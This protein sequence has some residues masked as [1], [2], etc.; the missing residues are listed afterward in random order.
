[1]SSVP[2]PPCIAPLFVPGDRPERFDK[3]ARSGADAVIIDLEDAVSPDSKE[4]ARAALRTSF[5]ALPV[6]VRVNAAGTAWHADDLAA[7]DALPLAGIVLPKADAEVDLGHVATRHALVALIETGKGIAD[8]RRV[9][10]HPRV[11][12]LAFGSIDYTADLGCGHTRQALLLPRSELV[13]ASRLAGLP[14]PLDGVTETLDDPTAV[15]A[16]A[17][18]AAELG[19]GGKLCIHP[20]QI[21]AVFQGMLPSQA[22]ITWAERVLGSSSGTNVIDGM[23]VDPPVRLRAANI[24]ARAG[25]V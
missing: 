11:V 22:D 8:A 7:V 15:E 20:K 25:R 4:A 6:F 24:L 14:P 18:H 1:M 3:A 17:R 16:D 19:F 9:A 5:T 12:R 10:A 23:M 2:T 13:L 21:P